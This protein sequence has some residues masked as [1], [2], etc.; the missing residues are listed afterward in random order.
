MTE[1]ECYNWD[2]KYNDNNTEKCAAKFTIVISNGK[3]QC[4]SKKVK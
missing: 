1:V 3:T 4:I 2:C